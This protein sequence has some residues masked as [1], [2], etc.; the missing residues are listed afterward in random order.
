MRAA[1]SHAR[2]IRPG[3]DGQAPG[4]P[5]GVKGG[6]MP[7]PWHVPMALRLAKG[8]PKG[9]R[10]KARPGNRLAHGTSRVSAGGAEES[11]RKTSQRPRK[12][13]AESMSIV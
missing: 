11:A 10:K 7:L 3:R 4:R 6:V 9:R 2:G 12:K 8:H 5:A 13:G 1:G